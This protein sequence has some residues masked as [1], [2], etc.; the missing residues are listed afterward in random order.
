MILADEVLV[1]RALRGD[2]AAFDALHAR[3]ITSL[4]R[5]CG[6][7]L[8]NEQEGEQAA[9]DSFVLAWRHLADFR[10]AGKFESWLKSIATGVCLKL[11]RTKSG[12]DT[13]QR[14]SL[15]APDTLPGTDGEQGAIGA[16]DPV[17][18]E[19][20]TR[21]LAQQIVRQVLECA[22][23]AKRPWDSLDMDIF[24]L[25]YVQGVESR[26][27]VAQRLGENESTVKYR[28]YNHIEPTF[29][30]VRQVYEESTAAI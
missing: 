9:Q 16:K 24:Q 17:A 5:Y 14:Q 18:D 3:H 11:W 12:K 13:L 19:V 4:S 8:R 1:S 20:E 23:T 26:R 15:D 22:A 30:A 25:H 28:V 21:I 29:K 6:R 2:P 7:L 10:G 27:E